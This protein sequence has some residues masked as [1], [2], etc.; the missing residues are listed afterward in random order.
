[1]HRNFKCTFCQNTRWIV[2]TGRIVSIQHYMNC[3]RVVD[4]SDHGSSS[5]QRNIHTAH[6]SVVYNDDTA[7]T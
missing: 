5:S 2:H 6:V 3:Q 4:V 7:L 1:M